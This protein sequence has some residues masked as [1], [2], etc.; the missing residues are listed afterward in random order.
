M[1]AGR[2]GGN[3]R[4]TRW[5]WHK[6]YRKRLTSFTWANIAVRYQVKHHTN[7][8]VKTVV[9]LSFQASSVLRKAL[10]ELP[11]QLTRFQVTLDNP[12]RIFFAGDE[13]KGNVEIDLSENLPIQ[14]EPDFTVL[15]V[16]INPLW[17]VGVR[18]QGR[19]PLPLYRQ[20]LFLGPVA[21]DLTLPSTH[22]TETVIW[23]SLNLSKEQNGKGVFRYK[24]STTS[25]NGLIS[26]NIPDNNFQTDN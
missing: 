12:N 24:C 25:E 3:G 19:S 23:E 9:F 7:L 20:R 8:I 18:R 22:T 5:H 14:G 4:G 16:S 17:T 13:L 11:P 2:R 21:P 26:T 1:K 10:K 6:V 15:Y